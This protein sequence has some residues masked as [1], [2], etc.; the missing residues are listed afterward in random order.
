MWREAHSR[1]SS[2]RALLRFGRAAIVA[3]ML[4]FSSAAWPQKA[5]TKPSTLE[6]AH[7]P[8]KP[9]PPK[10]VLGRTTPRGA[11]LG[12]LSA[13]RKGNGEIAA[14]YLNTPLRGPDAQALAQQLAAVLDRRLPPRLNELSDKPEGSLPDPLRPDE[15]LVG[16]ISTSK[17]DLDIVLERVDR[18]KLGT[19]WLFSRQT[20]DAIPDVFHELSTPPVERI[21][22]EILVK[23]RLASIPL[24]EWMAVFLGMPFLYLLTGVLNRLLGFG[25]GTC[26][27]YLLK[28]PN[29]PNPRI[30]SP[31]IRLLLLALTIY[32]MLSRVGLPLLARQF[33]STTVLIIVIA[34]STWLLMLLSR[35]GERYIIGRR[36][37]MS[38]SA[39]VLRLIR[40]VV[41]TLIFFASLLFA[42]YHFGIDPTAALAGLGVGGIAVALAAQKTLENVIAG[43]SLIAD[44]AVR[45]G[46]TLKLGDT[47]GTV[48]DVGLRSTSIRTLDR[49]LVSV[50]NGQIAN[51]SLE[52]LSARDKFWFH[53]LIGLRYETSPAQLRSIVAGIQNLLA[54]HSSLDPSSFRVNFLR[55]S[56]FSLD[57]D[58]FAYV[59]ARDWTE[60]LRIQ[61]ELLL[62]VIEIVHKAGAE[63]AFPSQTTYL[64]A[65]SA[66]KLAR[67]IPQFAAAHRIEA[68]DK[69]HGVHHQ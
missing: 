40:R 66:E 10:D 3:T 24:F 65:D 12:F 44:Q 18:G 53:P 45:V 5:G 34:A 6:A 27:R 25:A 26:R 43:V 37:K 19:V 28:N 14:L 42:L 63:V 23:T 39:A 38:G 11:V 59:F 51:M 41:N 61:E 35:W 58:I 20:L 7:E 32:W 33:W 69:E 54:E 29:L 60:F 15:D 13:A 21:L 2:D 16:T 8:T 4:L 62:S 36:P 52:I 64:A 55:L 17:G 48:V 47:V 56:A 57:V 1:S 49:T 50:P 9:S 67:L 30:L 46:D 22:P 68:L 31:P